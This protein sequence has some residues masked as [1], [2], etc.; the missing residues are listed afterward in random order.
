MALV[1]E[2]GAGAAARG[3][4]ASTA[5]T[6]T[7]G[8]PTTGTPTT[9]GHAGGGRQRA[10]ARLRPAL[11]VGRARDA[12][13]VADQRDEEADRADQLRPVAA[14]PPPGIERLRMRPW[15]AP[16]PANSAPVIIVMPP[17]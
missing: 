10:L 1:A 2:V 4:G 9:G 8:T 17:K 5:G 7:T 6:S 14:Q 15:V 12:V 11:P 16:S 3:G 13:G